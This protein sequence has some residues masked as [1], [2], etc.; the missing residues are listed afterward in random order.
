MACIEETGLATCVGDNG[1]PLLVKVKGRREEIGLAACV[2]D[3]VSPLL[4]KVVGRREEIGLATCV[5]GSFSPLLV[6]VIARLEEAGLAICVMNSGSPF[7]GKLNSPRMLH[8]IEAASL[9]KVNGQ[10]IVCVEETGLATCRGKRCSGSPF[11]VKVRR[12]IMTCAEVPGVRT[13]VIHYVS[14]Y[15]VNIQRMVYQRRMSSPPLS[16]QCPL[17]VKKPCT[18]YKGGRPRYLFCRRWKSVP[19]QGN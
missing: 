1:S 2:G 17:L 13:V 3:N 18:V 7:L 14:R 5:G 8:A 15:K 12:Q 6:K 16:G 19:C 4:V 10:R 11:L 9:P